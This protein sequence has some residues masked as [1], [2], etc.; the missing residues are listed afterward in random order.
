MSHPADSEL[1]PIGT[2]V[3]IIRGVSFGKTAVITGHNFLKDGKNF[4]NYYGVIDEREGVYVLYHD[5]IEV[6]E[7]PTA[8]EEQ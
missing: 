1:I 2:K 7:P 8:P 3:A 6:I 4:L 5:D